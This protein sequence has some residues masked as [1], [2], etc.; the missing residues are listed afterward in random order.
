M[1]KLTIFILFIFCVGITSAASKPQPKL[2]K[3]IKFIDYDNNLNGNYQQSYCLTHGWEML[4]AIFN[5]FDQGVDM[6]LAIHTTGQ[7]FTDC[8][9]FFNLARQ[10]QTNDMYDWINYCD[11]CDCYGEI[12]NY[13]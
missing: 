12:P 4:D 11:E 7:G 8:F 3:S 13:W 9:N 5:T 6:C 1:K 10:Q 2:L